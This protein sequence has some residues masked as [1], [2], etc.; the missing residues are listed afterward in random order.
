MDLLNQLDEYETL[1]E[2]LIERN[3]IDKIAGT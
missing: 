1:L 2:D 3:T